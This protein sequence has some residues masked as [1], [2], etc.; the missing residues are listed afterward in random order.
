MRT[1]VDDD[2][3]AYSEN[4]P[5]ATTI[6]PKDLEADT[7]EGIEMNE[8]EDEALGGTY[9]YNGPFQLDH[10]NRQE[11]N[12]SFGPIGQTQAP[13]ASEG[14]DEDLFEQSSNKAV[15]SSMSDDDDRNRMADFQDD[16]G[17]TADVFGTPPRGSTPMLDVP[18]QHMVEEEDESVTEVFLQDNEAP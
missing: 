12:W 2:L 17:T 7:L 11:P 6:D 1:G 16:E 14:E 18:P 10:Y 9:P 13:P 4:D 15:G 8:E 5:R 3:P